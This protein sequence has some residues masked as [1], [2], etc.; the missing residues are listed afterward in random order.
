MPIHMAWPCNKACN[1]C[2]CSKAANRGMA[3]CREVNGHTNALAVPCISTKINHD[4]LI[5]PFTSNCSRSRTSTPKFYCFALPTN[6]HRPHN[7]NR[8]ISHRTIP[9]PSLW[10]RMIIHKHSG[11]CPTMI[12]QDI[13]VIVH[14]LAASEP[15]T[16][17]KAI[18]QVV[19]WS[20]T[21]YVRFRRPSHPLC[22]SSA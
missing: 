19:R 18:A 17:S 11:S 12:T 22:T 5:A 14:S 3:T 21:N 7:R 4:V 16:R 1:K 13:S 15:N 10:R 8:F 20:L 9:A 6:I 2:Q